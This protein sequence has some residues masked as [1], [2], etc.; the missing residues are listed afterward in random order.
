MLMCVL[1]QFLICTVLRAH[2]IVV[3]ALYKINYYYK[4]LE[5]NISTK[6]FELRLLEGRGGGG[7]VILY[8]T[9]PPCG[10]F[11]IELCVTLCHPVLHCATFWDI[12]H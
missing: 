5:L 1:L 4:S 12:L 11:C 10:I 7:G 3:E 6:L 9:V 8:W 2:I